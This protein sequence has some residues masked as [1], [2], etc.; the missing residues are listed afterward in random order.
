[1]APLPAHLPKPKPGYEYKSYKRAQVTTSQ[2]ER[3]DR[4]EEN[5]KEATDLTTGLTGTHPPPEKIREVWKILVED[6]IVDPAILERM[7]SEH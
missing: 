7:K 3:P 6:G 5:L 1:M 2:Y 4:M